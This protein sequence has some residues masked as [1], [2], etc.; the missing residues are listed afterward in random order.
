VA[1]RGGARRFVV[2]SAQVHEK[3]YSKN[4]KREGR[5]KEK[6]GERERKER[7]GR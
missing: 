7:E 5:E 4:G 3:E 1:R 2:I 6:E